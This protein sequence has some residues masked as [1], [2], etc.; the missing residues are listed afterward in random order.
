MYFY[1]Y[2]CIIGNWLAARQDKAAVRF[3]KC[4]SIS[5]QIV[6]A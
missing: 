2:F 5:W 6:L 1:M 4:L 3:L